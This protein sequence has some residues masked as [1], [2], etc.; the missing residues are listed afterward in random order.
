MAA[1]TSITPVAT[2]EI[3]YCS[4]CNQ[5]DLPDQ[6]KCGITWIPKM[7][8]YSLLYKDRFI[9]W[10]L[11]EGIFRVSFYSDGTVEL[12]KI[13]KIP[14]KHSKCPSEIAVVADSK[15]EENATQNLPCRK[16]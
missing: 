15:E 12:R 4:Q 1:V 3:F 11:K 9:P 5:L 16:I 8:Y 13:S 6:A 2:S 10:K 7:G 14:W